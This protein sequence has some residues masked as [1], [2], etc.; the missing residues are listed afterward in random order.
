M[1]FCSLLVS[2]HFGIDMH[3]CMSLRFVFGLSHCN[4]YSGG[5]SILIDV[6]QITFIAYMFT[7]LL[8]L[9]LLLQ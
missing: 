9:N 2:Y 7:Q 3:A 5:I 8:R 4:H 1:Q 6:L